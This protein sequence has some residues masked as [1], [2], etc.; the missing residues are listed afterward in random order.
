MDIARQEI[1]ARAYVCIRQQVPRD[2]VGPFLG[3]AFGELQSF[4]DAHGMTATGP[5]TALYYAVSETHFDMAAALGVAEVTAQSE[6]V[7]A[8]DI[9][10]GPALVHE[11]KG[12]HTV[13][14]KE[15]KAVFEWIAKTVKASR[16]KK[17]R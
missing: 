11:H 8:C 5:P 9:A 3:P 7:E 6:R 16:K 4:I 1:E 14:R 15:T 17:K 10:A 2:Q 12:G 13:P